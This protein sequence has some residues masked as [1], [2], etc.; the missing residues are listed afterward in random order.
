MLGEHG[1]LQHLTKRLLDRALGTALTANFGDAP[2]VC[3]CS[4]AGNERHGTG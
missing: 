1:L 2:E 4:A 3:H